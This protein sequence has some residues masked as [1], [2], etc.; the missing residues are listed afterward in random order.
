MDIGVS[1][2]ETAALI[3]FCT[4][5]IADELNALGFSEQVGTKGT[6]LQW[7]SMAVIAQKV[8]SPLKK[9]H[10]FGKNSHYTRNY[11]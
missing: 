5:I 11:Y 3:N 9:K 1:Y 7:I 10:S 4:I 6:E 2:C 8:G